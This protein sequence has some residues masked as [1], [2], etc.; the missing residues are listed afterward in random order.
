MINQVVEEFQDWT[1]FCVRWIPGRIGRLIRRVIYKS[2]FNYAGRQ[3]SICEGV[4][5]K[6]FKNISI[7]SDF[8][9]NPNAVI[10]ASGD[11]T[12]LVIGNKFALNFGAMVIADH[13]L[14]EIGNGVMIGP[15]TVI[16][17]SN[18]GHSDLAT[19]LWEQNQVSGKVLIE[20]NVWIGANVVILPNV[21]VGTGCIIAAGAV[22]TKNTPPNTV[23]AGVPA[24][25]VKN[26]G[27]PD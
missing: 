2:L 25:V 16:R 18:H 5:I 26:R 14:L 19:L 6:G 21:T 3:I 8:F 1:G 24:R 10:H 11:S 22:V 4:I 9:I 12:R 27:R 17:T 20:D 23:V 15:N 7:G 13:G